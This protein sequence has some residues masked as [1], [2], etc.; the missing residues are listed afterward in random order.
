MRL[1]PIIIVPGQPNSIFFE[2]FFKSLN[3]KRIKSP[4]ILI[5]CADLFRF[6]AKK[7]KFNEGI[8]LI[9]S[10]NKKKN[11]IKN[12]IYI[13]DIKLKKNKLQ[14]IQLG[15]NKEYLNRCFY[16]SFKLLKKNITHKFL[17]GPIKK[18]KFIG[19]DYFGIT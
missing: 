15:H 8:N 11:L 19:K 13:F 1:K 17:N 7:Y 9:D 4:I 2:I 14:K 3:I 6:N 12:S 16:E 10:I 5:C 18:K